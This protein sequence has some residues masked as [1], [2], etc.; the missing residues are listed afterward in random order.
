MIVS[1]AAAD[2][3]ACYVARSI[4]GQDAPDAEDMEHGRRLVF[5]I[6]P[7][8]L[9]AERARL[10]TLI[11]P[12]KLELIAAALDQRGFPGESAEVQADLRLW[13]LV[14]RGGEPGPSSVAGMLI[15]AAEAIGAV[16][17]AAR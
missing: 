17:E 14:L 11:D 10:R 8:I 3:A 9:E 6:A 15:D 2:A 13:A 7:C 16:R 5:A 1:Q 4:Y 12:R